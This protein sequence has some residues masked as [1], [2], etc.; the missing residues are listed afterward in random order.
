[1]VVGGVGRRSSGGEGEGES[2]CPERT[3]EEVVV[4]CPGHGCGVGVGGYSLSGERGSAAAVHPLA[5][6][7]VLYGWRW[8]EGRASESRSGSRGV[9]GSECCSGQGTKVGG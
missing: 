8:G 4:S 2:R 1:V 5:G 9:G 6:E 7:G 3:H